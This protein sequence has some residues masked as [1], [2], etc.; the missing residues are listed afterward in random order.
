M[1]TSRWQQLSDELKRDVGHCE[2]CGSTA[3]LKAH[4]AHDESLGHE[5]PEDP[6]IPCHRWWHD[7]LRRGSGAL[8]VDNR[9]ADVTLYV[10]AGSV[11]RIRRRPRRDWCGTP[12]PCPQQRGYRGL[13]SS[14]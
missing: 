9:A 1:R 6:V 14:W 3:Q 13:R 4:H 2:A 5:T 12:R 8:G 7:I 10:D 11:R